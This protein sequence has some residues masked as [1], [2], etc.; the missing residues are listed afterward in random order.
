MTTV[1][2]SRIR[3][4]GPGVKCEEADIRL[5]EALCNSGETHLKNLDLSSNAVWMDEP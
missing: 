5:V 1:N 2:L 4:C 3:D